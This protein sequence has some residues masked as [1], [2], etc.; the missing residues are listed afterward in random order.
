[1]LFERAVKE[2]NIDEV[3]K[4]RIERALPR[5]KALLD[6]ERERI[7]GRL[8]SMELSA[9]LGLKTILAVSWKGLLSY[10]ETG[11]IVLRAI[12]NTRDKGL[13]LIF[14]NPKTH[15]LSWMRDIHYDSCNLDPA[16]L[17]DN[18]IEDN[19]KVEDTYGLSWIRDIPG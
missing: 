3:Q 5:V 4:K 7:I 15:G 9:W 13:R 14:Q 2:E 6:M 19:R 17:I 1:M 10:R 12:C 8:L 11:E 18:N 16:F